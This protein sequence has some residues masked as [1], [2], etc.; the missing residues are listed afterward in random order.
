MSQA[1]TAKH[2]PVVLDY[3]ELIDPSSQLSAKIEAAYGPDG[4][5]ILTV[6]GVPDL[7][8]RRRRLLPLAARLA[9]L[10][11]DV[12]ARYEDPE[13]SYNFGWSCGREML[14]HGL[15]DT[16]KGS[17]YANPLT[18]APTRDAALLAAHPAYCRPNLWPRSELPE[19]EAALKSLGA[20]IIDVGLLVAARCDDYVEEKRG[21]AP[22]GDGLRAVIHRSPCPKVAPVPG[23]FC[24][25]EWSGMGVGLLLLVTKPPLPSLP[26]LLQARL[27]HYFPPAPAQGQ[28]QGQGQG[29]GGQDDGWCGW[30]TDHGSLTGL[31]SAMYL[32]ARGGAE[33]ACPDPEAGL[34]IRTRTG[35]SG[36]G[37]CAARGLRS[38]CAVSALA[39][40]VPAAW[41][42]P[43]VSP[44]E[45][46]GG[47]RG[48]G[49]G[50]TIRWHPTTGPAPS[51]CAAGEVVRAAIPADHIGF[52]VGEAA[53]VQSGGL[54]RAT[55][56]CV[57]APAGGRAAG[58]SRNTFAVFM[59]PRWDEGMGGVG[60]ADPGVA[61]WTPGQT[62]GEFS[63]RR[64]AAYYA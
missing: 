19:L 63:E 35:E 44:E 6:R 26:F 37:L 8:A 52:Q 64:F 22:R 33:V 11:A 14:L 59:Q 4:M 28:G 48:G 5:G 38:T 31:T 16:H 9:A 54:L 62:F 56:H 58:A 42:P 32:D 36:A 47:E 43:V 45:R 13:S 25:L 50:G 30:H 60:G 1:S 27:L 49:G 57:R 46:E 41:C 17:F 34:F 20:L 2:E 12:K 39:A 18:D 53:Q 61:Q 10:P 3:A 21:G 23:A 55:P 15:P 29:A 24:A 51:Q 40:A 7:P